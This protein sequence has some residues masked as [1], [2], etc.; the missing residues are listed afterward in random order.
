M[1]KSTS[2]ISSKTSAEKSPWLNRKLRF[3]SLPSSGRTAPAF[4]PARPHSPRPS[5]AGG[6]PGDARPGRTRRQQRS[7]SPAPGAW[8]RT[9]ER[10]DP[11]PG[12]RTK[13]EGSRRRGSARRRG[14]GRGRHCGTGKGGRLGQGS[15]AGEARRR[16]GRTLSPA[17]WL[18]PSPSR[19]AGPGAAAHGEPRLYLTPAGGARGQVGDFGRQRAGRRSRELGPLQPHRPQCPPRGGLPH[20]VLPRSGSSGTGRGAR[21][22]LPPPPPA[23]RAAPATMASRCSTQAA[24]SPHPLTDSCSTQT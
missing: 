3:A 22:P 10:G 5:R 20:P 11:A 2:N 23:R 19:L 9:E 14:A 1:S 8:Q 13:Q 24:A 17:A 12:P 4:P 21:G 15:L 7:G 16:K 18:P 6:A